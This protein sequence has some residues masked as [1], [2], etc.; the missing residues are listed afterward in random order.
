MVSGPE[1]MVARRRL[2]ALDAARRDSTLMPTP[3]QELQTQIEALKA[4]VDFVRLASQL[5][6]RVGKVLQWQAQGEETELARTI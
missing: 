4:D 6:L 1:K 5:R 2:V 3:L